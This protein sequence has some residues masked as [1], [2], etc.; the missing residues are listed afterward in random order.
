MGWHNIHLKKVWRSL[1][2]T[3]VGL[4]LILEEFPLEYNGMEINK[5]RIAVYFLKQCEGV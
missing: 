5:K 4:V 3:I 1:M 2:L